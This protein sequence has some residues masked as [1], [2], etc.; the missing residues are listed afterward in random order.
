MF[1]LQAGILPLEVVLYPDEHLRHE[2]FQLVLNLIMVRTVITPTGPQLTVEVPE[3]LV[4]QPVQVIV[5]L[6]SETIPE[7]LPE[8][9]APKAQDAFKAFRVDL[10]PNYKFDRDEAALC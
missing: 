7:V 6:A 10:G 9:P 5:A 3:T 1:R 2:Y 8:L 4:G